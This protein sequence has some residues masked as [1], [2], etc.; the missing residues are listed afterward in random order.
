MADILSNETSTFS[1]TVAAKQKE[2]GWQG[3][4]Y[5]VAGN[6]IGGQLV[7]ASTTGWVVAASG[8]TVTIT[9]Q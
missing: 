8:D 3:V 1:K 4:D 5:S 7:D 9:A 6:E 2:D